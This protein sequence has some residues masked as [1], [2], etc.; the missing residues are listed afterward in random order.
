MVRWMIPV[1][2][3]TEAACEKQPSTVTAK[4]VAECAISNL[5]VIVKRN[6]NSL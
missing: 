1:L 4:L 2:S 6:V 5:F 3:E